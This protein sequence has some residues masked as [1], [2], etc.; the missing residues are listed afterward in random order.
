MGRSHADKTVRRR[1]RMGTDTR[2]QDVLKDCAQDIYDL[3]LSINTYY[4]AG[5]YLVLRQGRQRNRSLYRRLLGCAP[6]ML[7]IDANGP[8]HTVTICASWVRLPL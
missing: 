1:W 5:N 7:A 8:S 6:G 2:N 4:S 3:G